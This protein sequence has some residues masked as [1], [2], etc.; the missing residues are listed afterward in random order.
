MSRLPSS[1]SL[2]IVV[3]VCLVLSLA[4]AAAPLTAETTSSTSV[5]QSIGPDG[6]SVFDYGFSPAFASDH[7]VFAGTNDGVYMST[8]G[9]V[10]WRPAKR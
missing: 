10:S 5:W 8:D 9:G 3:A 7:T 4:A 1:G 2:S 6:G